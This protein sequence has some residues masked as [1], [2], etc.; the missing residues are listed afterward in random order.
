MTEI[1]QY[2]TGKH[3]SKQRRVNSLTLGTGYQ[4]P[5]LAKTLLIY[6]HSS[7]LDIRL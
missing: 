7:G 6:A 5:G 4:E 3:V 1:T 2:S